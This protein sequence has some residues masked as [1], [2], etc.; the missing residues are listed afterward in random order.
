MPGTIRSLLAK[1]RPVIRSDGT[2]VR[3]Y[4]YVED[5]A[6][7]YMRLAERLDDDRVQGEAFNFSNEAPLTVLGMVTL[8]QKLMN[9]VDVEPEIRSFAK[10]EIRSQRLSAAKAREVLGWEPGFDLESGLQETISWYQAFLGV[11]S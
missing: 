5:V 7:A 1:E 8:I 9:A 2:Y 4:I 3:D 10:G 11:R 6:R